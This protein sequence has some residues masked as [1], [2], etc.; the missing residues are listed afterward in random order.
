MKNWNSLTEDIQV[1][2]IG[3]VFMFTTLIVVAGVSHIIEKIQ[4]SLKNN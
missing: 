3:V 4:E 1:F 2:V